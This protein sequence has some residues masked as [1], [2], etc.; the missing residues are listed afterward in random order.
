M[1][2]KIDVRGLSCPLPVVEV[3]KRLLAVNEGMFEV[4]G[5]SGTAKDNLVRMATNIGWKVEYKDCGEEFI[6]YISKERQTKEK[7]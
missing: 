6:L 3:R 1:I 2:E 5:D 7:I 4:L